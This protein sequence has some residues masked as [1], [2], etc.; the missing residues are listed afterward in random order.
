M[1]GACD[2]NE[3]RKK[4]EVNDSLEIEGEKKQYILSIQV[5]FPPGALIALPHVA[6]C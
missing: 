2:V 3:R 6:L 4:Y 5:I 1:C